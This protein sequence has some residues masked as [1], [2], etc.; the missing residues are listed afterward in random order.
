MLNPWV[1][2]RRDQ[3]ISVNK[4]VNEKDQM[5]KGLEEV[6]KKKCVVPCSALGHTNLKA[7]F[8]NGWNSQILLRTS[9]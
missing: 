6:E 9:I 4:A 7:L 8:Y 5:E 3:L 1:S 2:L